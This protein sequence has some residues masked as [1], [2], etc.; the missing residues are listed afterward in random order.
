MVAR[1][2]SRFFRCLGLEA[3]HSLP[4]FA[5]AASKGKVCWLQGIVGFQATISALMNS[6]E[7]C[8]CHPSVVRERSELSSMEIPRLIGGPNDGRDGVRGGHAGPV[9][10]LGVRIA[11]ML[12]AQA[13]RLQAAPTTHLAGG[14]GDC[15]GPFAIFA[16]HGLFVWAVEMLFNG[17]I[18]RFKERPTVSVVCL[19]TP[20]PP[21]PITVDGR[22][23]YRRNRDSRRSSA[24]FFLSG[25]Q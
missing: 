22:G 23:S 10:D 2:T 5:R 7:P 6:P 19:A 8:P 24:S 11:C 15:C 1:A 18:C 25:R 20:K 16:V 3:Y 17:L 4:L 9:S 21:C 13:S 14:R 12:G